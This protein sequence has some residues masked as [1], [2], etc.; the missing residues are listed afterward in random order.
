MLPN[1]NYTRFGNERVFG[2]EVRTLGGVTFNNSSVVLAPGLASPNFSSTSRMITD[3]F[4]AELPQSVNDLISFCF[5]DVTTMPQFVVVDFY[6]ETFQNIICSDTLTYECPVTNPCLDLDRETVSLNCND[7]DDNSYRLSLALTN[8]PGGTFEDIGYIKLNVTGPGG[9]NQQIDYEPNPVIGSGDLFLI[10]TVLQLPAAVY[11][12]SLCILISAHDTPEERLCCFVDSLCIP[13]PLCD[14]CPFVDAYLQVNEGD[15]CCYTLFV[16]DLVPIN[17]YFD[18]LTIEL[19]NGPN[20]TL[21][22]SNIITNFQ[23]SG[24][25]ITPGSLYGYRYQGTAGGVIGTAILDFCVTPDFSP[26]STVLKVTWYNTDL[27]IT[28]MD[29]V[30]AICQREDPC[31]EIETYLVAL[32]VEEDDRQCC[33]D[34]FATNNYAADPTIFQS[35]TVDLIDGPSTTYGGVNILPFPSGWNPTI[36]NVV[37][38]S[39]TFT[40]PSGSIPVVADTRLFGFCLDKEFSID[41]TDIEV[42]W[43]TRTDTI[44]RDTLSAFC[45]GCLTVDN[46]SIICQG[47]GNYTYL[48]NFT[49]H[50]AFPVNTVAIINTNPVTPG[51]IQEEYISL[52]VTVQPGNSYTGFLPV[53]LTGS[54]GD[55]VCFDVVMR[56]VLPDEDLNIE[57][58]YALVCTTL[59]DCETDEGTCIFEELIVQPS[60]CPVDTIELIC[61][62]DGVTYA[63]ACLAIQAGV[64]DYRYCENGTQSR[65]EVTLSGE[66]NNAGQPNLNWNY[67]RNTDD[68]RF[69]ELRQRPVGTTDWQ[70]LSR[71][72]QSRSDL[73]AGYRSPTFLLTAL[74]YQLIAVTERGEAVMSNVVILTPGQAINTLQ[75]SV[76][77]NPVTATVLITS[78]RRATADL[79]IINAAGIVRHEQTVDLGAAPVQFDATRLV[80]GVYTIQLSYADGTVGYRRFIK[81]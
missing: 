48:F 77:P 28:C 52:G 63:N 44:C 18:S 49:N 24:T 37:G 79:R 62:C 6:D 41:S 50:S 73:T 81:Q 34:V 70:R 69:Q 51:L 10:D 27:E 4:L 5:S 67:R 32:P 22:S 21:G 61:A 13:I 2:I 12:D 14:P 11:G 74:E 1:L 47:D 68:I 7:D 16:D 30:S 40:H 19:V 65:N 76:Y 36:T 43:M 3:L 80:P 59:S 66:L 55:E 53:Q 25:E 58:C 42:S 31:P 75:I 56:Y 20:P 33:F 8:P 29:S 15:S 57:C 71:T 17:P 35:I 9:F 23:W 38:Q 64:I 72:D 60:T 39:Y 46:D 26:D 78:N 45:P 54:S